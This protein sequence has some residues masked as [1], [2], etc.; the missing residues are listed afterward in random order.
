MR[1][2]TTVIFDLG[3][4][5]VKI[6]TDG[7]KFGRL[8]RAM[9][10]EPAQAFATYW[11]TPEVRQ[12]MA[13]E[14][15]SLEFYYRAKERF[16]LPHSYNEFVEGWCDLFSPYPEMEELFARVAERYPVGLLSD[17]DPLHWAHIL[18]HNPWLKKI[19]KPSLSY[20]IG[21]L[22]P[23]PAMFNAAAADCGRQKRQCLFI[24]DVQANADGARHYG[25]P[26]LLFT[27]PEKLSR[28]LRG[29]GIL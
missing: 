16:D 14:M 13:G 17:T 29:L 28:D 12:H 6:G 7:D 8:M 10:I 2:I 1:D 24:D 18:A 5:L 3:R 23:H 22:K 21:Y 19:A 15:D 27:G 9:R 26:A 25:M 11:F 20:E 4:V